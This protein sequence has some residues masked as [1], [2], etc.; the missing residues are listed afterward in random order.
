LGA[1]FLLAACGGGGGGQQAEG[2][3]AEVPV[4]D[5]TPGVQQTGEPV[6]GPG[7][8]APNIH[9]TRTPDQMIAAGQ[10]SPVNNSGVRGGVNM[11]G[12]GEQTEVSMNVSGVP[13][14]QQVQAALV[15]GACGTAG[16]SVAEIGPLTV[17]AGGVASVTDT[18]PL[19]PA[20]VMSGA[21]SLIVKGQNAGPATPA[22]AC[23]PI[24]KSEPM[25]P[26]S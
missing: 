3:G 8:A 4:S 11:R 17:G 5:A 18:V 25:L 9:S 14:G 7:D 2:G 12:I 10:L 1:L 24:P 22:L 19:P 15:Q 26:T 6:G 20:T 21:H 16:T 23:S 13:Q